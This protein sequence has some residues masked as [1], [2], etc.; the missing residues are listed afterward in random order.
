MTRE[1]PRASPSY[2]LDNLLEPY[3]VEVTTVLL[4]VRKVILR[5]AP[6]AWERAYRGWKIVKY[7]DV[8]YLSP[9]A[10]GVHAGFLKGA[11]LPDPHGLLSGDA[12]E[13]RRVWIRAGQD[14]L[15]HGLSELI[16]AAFEYDRCFRGD[17]Q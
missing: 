5:L 7:D 4:D 8:I 16:E 11:Y 3:P 12:Q 10:S 15:H 13:A 14:I 1:A 6:N 9:N 17:Q 2:T